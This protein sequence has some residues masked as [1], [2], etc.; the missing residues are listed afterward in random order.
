MKKRLQGIVSLVKRTLKQRVCNHR[1]KV[2]INQVIDVNVPMK[3]ECTKCNKIVY[4][5]RR[6][7]VTMEDADNISNLTDKDKSDI[8]AFINNLNTQ[9]GQIQSQLE[10][11]NNSFYSQNTFNDK[12]SRR[13][14]S[15]EYVMRDNITA[16]NDLQKSVEVIEDNLKDEIDSTDS[17]IKSIVVDAIDLNNALLIQT[18]LI[19][20]LSNENTKLHERMDTIQGYRTI[21]LTQ[22]CVM[23]DDVLVITNNILIVTDVDFIM[24]YAEQLQFESTYRVK[25]VRDYLENDLGF[26]HGAWSTRD[27]LHLKWLNVTDNFIQGNEKP[28]A[29]LQKCN[30]DFLI[31]NKYGITTEVFKP[32]NLKSTL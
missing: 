5:Q 10:Y 21:K 13:L 31:D 9:I 16:I 19:E 6:T 26:D 12:T 30:I 20:R 27:F 23:E 1:Y 11:L 22:G 29:D 32:I 8:L 15:L 18:D 25:E 3:Y 17:R 28:R 14:D 2:N 24:K 4:E 7:Q